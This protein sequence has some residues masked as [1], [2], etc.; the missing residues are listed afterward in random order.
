MR[1]VHGWTSPSPRFTKG[2]LD[3]ATPQPWAL[4][5][6]ASCRHDRARTSW[7]PTERRQHGPRPACASRE[8]VVVA[9]PRLDDR[10]GRGRHRPLWQPGLRGLQEPGPPWSRAVPSA[11]A[12]K[13][14]RPR[15]D[16]AVRSPTR[17]PYDNE[18]RSASADASRAPPRLSGSPRAGDRSWARAVAE[19]R[20]RD[21]AQVLRWD[22]LATGSSNRL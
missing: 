4:P 8:G 1:F 21:V 20:R 11:T 12:P 18:H 10:R 7:P 15:W 2:H 22:R 9:E 6:S 17:C 16:R 5:R 19:R 13:P 14:R 3:T